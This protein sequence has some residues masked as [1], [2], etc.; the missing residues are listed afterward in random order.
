MDELMFPGIHVKNPKGGSPSFR[1]LLEPLSS[2][3]PM[4]MSSSSYIFFVFFFF[5][6]KEKQPTHSYPVP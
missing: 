1:R 5:T 4:K 2:I 3:S 6:E